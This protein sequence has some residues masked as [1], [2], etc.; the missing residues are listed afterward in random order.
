MP[1]DTFGWGIRCIRVIPTGLNG[2][3]RHF[4][5]R[6]RV[7][8]ATAPA[9]RITRIGNR[10]WQQFAPAFAQ[11]HAIGRCSVE[12]RFGKIVF[13]FRGDKTITAAPFRAEIALPLPDVGIGNAFERLRLCVLMVI[14]D[15]SDVNPYAFYR[16]RTRC[17]SRIAPPKGDTIMVFFTRPFR[18]V[19]RL[20]P[21]FTSRC[22]RRHPLNLMFHSILFQDKFC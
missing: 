13:V 2:R 19:F 22:Y 5:R 11:R 18:T 12:N 21:G 1:V 9:L 10:L 20:P 8:A 7:P 6:N 14:G 16:R 4:Q 15:A 3:V 17:A